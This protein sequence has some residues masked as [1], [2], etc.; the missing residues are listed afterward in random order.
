MSRAGLSEQHVK[1]AF[2]LVRVSEIVGKPILTNDHK[3]YWV[4]DGKVVYLH[5]VT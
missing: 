3:E 5:S 1:K 2:D 4:L